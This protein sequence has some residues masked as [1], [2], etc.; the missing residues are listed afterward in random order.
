MSP[1]SKMCQVDT[2]TVHDMVQAG[3]SAGRNVERTL[4]MDGSDMLDA[5]A[6][7]NV[8][9]VRRDLRDAHGMEC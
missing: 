5:S 8:E 4:D 9:L 7:R 1:I 6:L 2:V 3:F